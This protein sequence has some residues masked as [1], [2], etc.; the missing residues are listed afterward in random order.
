VREKGGGRVLYTIDN[1][2]R[3]EEKKKRRK[4]EKKKRR[5]GRKLESLNNVIR[6]R[7]FG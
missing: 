5:K 6:M 7:R 4:E 3:K 1:K 2:E